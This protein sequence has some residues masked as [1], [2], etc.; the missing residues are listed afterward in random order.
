MIN[1]LLA[2]LEIYKQYIMNGNYKKEHT[3]SAKKALLEINA[4]E[5]LV[6]SNQSLNYFN[7]SSLRRDIKAVFNPEYFKEGNASQIFNKFNEVID[8]IKK[9]IKAGIDIR[10]KE[11]Q[12]DKRTYEYRKENY[13][14]NVDTASMEKSN[15]NISSYLIDSFYS[16]FKKEPSSI[17]DYF[18]L[19]DRMTAKL[20]KIIEKL[21]ELDLNIAVLE[22]KVK[23]NDEKRLEAIS[24]DKINDSYNNL[25]LKLGETVTNLYGKQSE[26]KV[27]LK[28][29]FNELCPVIDDKCE[30]WSIRYDDLIEEKN[31][32]VV[33]YQEAKR[34]GNNKKAKAIL[35][36][37]EEIN[38]KLEKKAKVL[39][40]GLQEYITALVIKKDHK[41]QDIQKKYKD[42]ISETNLTENRYNYVLDNK[43]ETKMKIKD[44]IE[45]PY[46]EVQ[47]KISSVL[48]RLHS[49]RYRLEKLFNKLN[50]QYEEFLENNKQYAPCN[51]SK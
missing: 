49:R 8:K 4:F 36:K 24:D 25:C 42:L 35:K 27:Q 9:E 19:V 38:A 11:E 30:E 28:K 29:R 5:E 2:C 39:E 31:I 46:I 43:E 51:K 10:F 44:S 45:E 22:R 33:D 17:L 20:D 3:E 14:T 16:F 32:L 37:L 34:D 47:N 7:Y 48:T 6:K 23:F 15:D 40:Y 13:V 21:K 12:T 18:H 50:T 26:K 1:D 41:Y